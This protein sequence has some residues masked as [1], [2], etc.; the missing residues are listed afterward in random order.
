[1]HVKR[2]TRNNFVRFL[3]EQLRANLG[4]NREVYGNLLFRYQKM[5]PVFFT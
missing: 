1:M 2:C 3:L 4:Q 5:I